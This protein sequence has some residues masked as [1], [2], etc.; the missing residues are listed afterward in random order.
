MIIIS[1]DEKIHYK[2]AHISNSNTILIS[3]NNSEYNNFVI[4][5]VNKQIINGYD[6]Y[7]SICGKENHFTVSLINRFDPE[8]ATYVMAKDLSE[9]ANSS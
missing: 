3:L 6:D 4:F 5:A 7:I 8:Y 1:P 9:Q 2:I